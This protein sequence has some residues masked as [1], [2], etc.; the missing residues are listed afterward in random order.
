LVVF[1]GFH[2]NLDWRLISDCDGS[3]GSG[4]NNYNVS[5]STEGL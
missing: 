1:V 2:K 3:T 5:T 4:L